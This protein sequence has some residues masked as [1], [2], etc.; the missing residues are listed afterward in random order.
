MRAV[1]SEHAVARIGKL[2]CGELSQVRELH[3]GV[4]VA[5]GLMEGM[6]VGGIGLQSGPVTRKRGNLSECCAIAFAIHGHAKQPLEIF[7]D[8]DRVGSAPPRVETAEGEEEG[9]MAA[10]SFNTGYTGL[11]KPHDRRCRSVHNR[12]IALLNAVFKLARLC[13]PSGPRRL[14]V[15]EQQ[16]TDAAIW[17]LYRART[18]RSRY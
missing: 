10:R 18:C 2:G 16:Y 11:Q 4:S 6:I 14:S 12:G 3:G 5:R 7:E 13:L 8:D 1:L 9:G 15:V 17:M